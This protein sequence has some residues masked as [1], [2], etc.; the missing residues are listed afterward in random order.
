MATGGKTN[1]EIS[2]LRPDLVSSEA[3]NSCLGHF[4]SADEIG[5]DICWKVL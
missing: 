2:R 5:V 3:Y 1:L 4:R